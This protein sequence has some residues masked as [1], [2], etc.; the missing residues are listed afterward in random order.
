MAYERRYLVSLRVFEPIEAHP[1]LG[2]YPI[3]DNRSMLEELVSADADQRLISIPPDPIADSYRGTPIFLTGEEYGDGVTRVCPVQDDIRSWHALEALSENTSRD[4]LDMLVPK[5]ARR[6]AAAR[7]VE[8]L[9]GD[10]DERVFTRTA[11]WDVSPVWWLAFDLDT[12]RV[13]GDEAE[14]GS[15]RAFLRT[16]ILA[17]SARVEWAH[18]VMEKKSRLQA[19]V[20][21]TKQ[22][23]V[24]LETFD[25]NSVLEL[26]LGG[27]SDVLD[28]ALSKDYV[29]SWI[30]ALDSDDYDSAVAA[31]NLYTRNWEQLGL[32]SRSN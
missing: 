5:S 1:E 18:S 20:E 11:A 29:D 4:E 2:D 19:V 24:W 28:P 23:A 14:D 22:F 8:W 27:M 9:Q 3:S 32:F 21:S 6:R 25:P 7:R 26:D 10:P 13:L 17:A 30:D 16:D 15:R 12:D 31:F